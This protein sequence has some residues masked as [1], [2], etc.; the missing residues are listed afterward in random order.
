M[1]ELMKKLMELWRAKKLTKQNLH[2][3]FSMMQTTAQQALGIG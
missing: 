1:Y 3:A 2:K